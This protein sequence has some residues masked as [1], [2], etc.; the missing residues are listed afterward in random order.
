MRCVSSVFAVSQINIRVISLGLMNPNQAAG[1]DSASARD[2]G[3]LIPCNCPDFVRPC[4]SSPPHGPRSTPACSARS[5]CSQCPG[6]VPLH[7][8]ARESIW[9]TALP[10]CSN[11]PEKGVWA[12]LLFPKSDESRRQKTLAVAVLKARFAS[13]NLPPIPPDSAE[14]VLSRSFFISEFQ[15]YPPPPLCPLAVFG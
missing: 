14:S 9:T 11:T 8:N 10:W 15:L 3:K 6:F 1:Y 2:F 12:S 7:G 4:F 13:M 5:V